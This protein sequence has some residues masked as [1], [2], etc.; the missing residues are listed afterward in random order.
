MHHLPPAPIRAIPSIMPQLRP[1]PYPTLLNGAFNPDP[2]AGMPEYFPAVGF[3]S[4]LIGRGLLT[5]PGPPPF[6]LVLNLFGDA[7]ADAELGWPL[8]SSLRGGLTG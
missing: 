5:T 2:G 3:C 6:A 4:M 8:P 1:F 7:A